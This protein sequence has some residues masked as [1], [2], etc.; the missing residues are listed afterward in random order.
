MI[1]HSEDRM[2][3]SVDW[4]K[5]KGEASA[6][7]LRVRDMA[8]AAVNSAV[9]ELDEADRAEFMGAAIRHLRTLYGAGEGEREAV[10]LFGSLAWSAALQTRRVIAGAEADQAFSRLAVVND[11]EKA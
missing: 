8:K 10:S 3:G 6:R 9:M 7:I 4:K 2:L 1:N 5:T 11:G